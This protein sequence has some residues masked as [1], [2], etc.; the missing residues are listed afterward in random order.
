MSLDF[1]ITVKQTVY[2]GNMTH[3]V[4]DMWREAGCYDALYNSEGMCAET[5]KPFLQKALKAMVINKKGYETLNPEN[6]WGDYQSAIEYLKEVLEACE[7][8]PE[9]IISISK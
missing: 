2:S 7:N 1:S 6:G 5:I 4:A 8:N 9:G 3:N